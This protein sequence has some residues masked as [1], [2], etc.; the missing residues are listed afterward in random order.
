ARRAGRFAA[1]GRA[2]HDAAASAGRA[3]GRPADLRAAGRR[4]G[5]A[6]RR[7]LRSRAGRG[8][9][10]IGPSAAGKSTLARL[11]AGTWAPTAGKVRLDGAEIAVWHDSRGSHHIGYLPQDIELFAGSVRDNIARLSD[12]TPGAIIEA[13][14]LVGLHEVIMAATR[15]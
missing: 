9:G 5:D 15:L 7:L 3:R 1:A 6:A 10:R 2:R 12:G 14:S 11:I 13:A 8:A 4:R